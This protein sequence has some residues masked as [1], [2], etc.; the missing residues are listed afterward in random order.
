MFTNPGFA[1]WAMFADDIK[2]KPS[3]FRKVAADDAVAFKL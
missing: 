3:S 1:E 2:F